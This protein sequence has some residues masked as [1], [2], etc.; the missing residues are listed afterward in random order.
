MA[1]LKFRFSLL[2]RYCC[3]CLVLLILLSFVCLVTFL[4]YF[5]KVR[6]LCYVWFLN[7][8]LGWLSGDLVIG[9][10]YLYMP[11]KVKFPSHCHGV[12]CICWTCLQLAARQ[13]TTLSQGLKV[14][15]S[16]PFRHLLGLCRPCHSHRQVSGLLDSQE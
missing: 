10:R 12:L 1:T 3:Y 16:W 6:I 7:A 8:L 4:N 14:N 13:S 15:Q 5:R 9:Q 2:S 11:G